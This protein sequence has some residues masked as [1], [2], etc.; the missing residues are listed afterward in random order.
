M[1]G[2]AGF[3][4]LHIASHFSSRVPRKGFATEESGGLMTA[5]KESS[6]FERLAPRSLEWRVPRPHLL[7][8]SCLTCALTLG[9]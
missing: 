1:D 8:A 2:L 4:R 7:A 3:T 9:F 5:L 6:S